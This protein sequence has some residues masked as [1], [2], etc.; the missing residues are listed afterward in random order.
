MQES[1][2]ARRAQ[3]TAVT[4]FWNVADGKALPLCGRLGRAETLGQCAQLRGTVTGEGSA[5]HRRQRGR[6]QLC[7]LLKSGRKVCCPAGGL[8]QR[9]R[10][11]CRTDTIGFGE[12]RHS[13]SLREQ[14][15]TE[16]RG[17]GF[18]G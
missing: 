1:D 18:V 8:E 4:R 17:G 14:V 16:Q 12:G 2:Y 9:L 11:Q 15:T 7:Q 5:V 6:L 10:F 13:A 3:V